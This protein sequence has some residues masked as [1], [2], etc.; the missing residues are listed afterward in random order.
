MSLEA[1]A[2]KRT[3]IQGLRAVA[4][5]SVVIYHAYGSLLPGG[6]VGVDIF[7]VISGFVISQSI[8][9]DIDAGKFSI[10][11]FYR[12]R[13]RR[14]FPALYLMLAAVLLASWFLLS[15][16]A[17][18]EL[19]QSAFTTIFFSSNFFFFRVAGYFGGVSA[20]KPLLHTWSLAVEE[21][22]YLLYP[23]FV[24]WMARYKPRLLRAAFIALSV[25]SLALSAWLVGPHPTADFYFAPPR[26]FELLMG[27][28]IAVSR[29]P[30]RM[31]PAVREGLALLGM[32]CIGLSLF[33]FNDLTPFP[34]FAAGLPCA[35]AAILIWIGIDSSTLSSKLLS[36]AP[37]VFFGDLS[38]S[39]YLWHWP[40][41]VFTRHYLLGTPGRLV[42]TLCAG[43]AVLLAFLSYRFVE[44]PILTTRRKSISYLTLGAAAMAAATCLFLPI[45][46]S[47][48]VPG[49][50]SPPV[51]EVF[52]SANS[53]NHQR[54]Q[55]NGVASNNI[56][57]DRNC[58]FGAAGSRPDVAVWGDSYGAELSVAIGDV[59]KTQNRSVMEISASGCPPSTGFQ[60]MDNRSCTAHNQETLDRLK[61]DEKIHTVVLTANFQAYQDH[62]FDQLF[63]G[64]TNVVESLKA[65]G[66]RI[67]M[68]YPVP[69]MDFDPP[70]LLGFRLKE[71]KDLNDVGTSQ[72]AF[73][74]NTERV[75]KELDAL[76]DP[77]SMSRV[78]PAQLLCANGLCRAYSTKD[79][80]LYFDYSHLNVTGGDK[81]VA[82]AI[83][84]S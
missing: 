57:Y 40:V 2:S 41:L 24:Y 4:V 55:C 72:T 52:A 25:V 44:T 48:G 62:K 26:A 8:L 9:R 7:F 10:A 51:R 15:P 17:F 68:V 74:Q 36:V 53:F 23:L 29:P 77:S 5:L 61:D 49:R 13:V 34:G 78:Y 65:H 14:I 16:S 79:G 20:W 32:L 37:M 47:D 46:Y 39:L 50:F 12:R 45:I 83:P 75:V 27:C 31:G 81:L 42:T 19:G 33:F 63:A 58:I 54:S 67:V 73:E 60:S 70:T 6:F 11:N 43:A 22:F 1:H 28:I 30:S 18:R 21:Q 3:D 56:P 66:K 59:L 84:L 69:H 76:Y 35:G 71:R 80:P 64:Y 82:Q 38:Y